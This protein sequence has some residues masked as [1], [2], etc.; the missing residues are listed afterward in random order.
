MHSNSEVMP[1]MVNPNV[2]DPLKELNK[3]VLWKHE[4]KPNQ[5]KPT[6]VPYNPTTGKRASVSDPAT[7]SD[8]ETACRALSAGEYSGIGFVFTK[9]DPFV[10]IDLDD[11]L[12][13]NNNTWKPHAEYM[14]TIFSQ[15]AWET[16]QSGNGLHGIVRVNDKEVLSGKKR[17]WVDESGNCY[18]CYIEG[19]FIAYGHCDWTR[20]DLPIIDATILAALLPDAIK[21]KDQTID[22][23]DAA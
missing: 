1:S 5:K 23:V 14:R 10:F 18:E 11:C 12:D 4:Q 6:K 21:N 16:S 2:P 15:G 19:R 7:W 8:Y 17:K 22:W 9:D 3:F 13:L 20:L